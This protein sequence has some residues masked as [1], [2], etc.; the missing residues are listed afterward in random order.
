MAFPTIDY[1]LFSEEDKRKLPTAQAGGNLSVLSATISVTTAALALNKVSRVLWVPAGFQVWGISAM[2]P[3][4]DS[5]GSAALVW[6]L[7]DSG[8]QNRLIAGST[9][10]QAAGNLT[11]ASLPT[12]T[13]VGYTYTADTDILMTV[14]TA[15]ATAVAGTVY[16]ALI[17]QMA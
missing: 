13:A 17:G 10:G 16:L 15:A 11:A 2:L 12:L 8:D 3:D 1:Y 5:G 14:T 7:G 4:L 6:D 9:V